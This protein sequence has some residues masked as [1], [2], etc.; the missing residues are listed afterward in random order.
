MRGQV[1]PVS[2]KKRAPR[3]YPIEPELAK[4][5]RQHRKQLFKAQAPGVESGWMFPSS[6]GTARSPSSLYKA[7]AACSKAAGID[8]RFTVHGLRYTFNDLSRHAKLDAVVRRALTGHVTEEMQWHYSNV[9]LDEKR[10]AI[11]EIIR[12]APLE[13]DEKGG[14]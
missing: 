11:A 10:A 4:V 12:I 14:D 3:E 2:R 6:V 7:W 9:S 1:G 13:F 8:R 5:L